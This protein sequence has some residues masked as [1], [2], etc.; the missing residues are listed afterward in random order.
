MVLLASAV[1]SGSS[2]RPHTFKAQPEV[3][4][5]EAFARR[6]ALKHERARYRSASVRTSV[7]ATNCGLL[8]RGWQQMS[9]GVGVRTTTTSTHSYYWHVFLRL[10]PKT[11]GFVITSLSRFRGI[12]PAP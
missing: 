7:V 1:A 9:C 8:G 2:Q 4:R 12:P 10:D 11:G 5:A 3:K 6:T